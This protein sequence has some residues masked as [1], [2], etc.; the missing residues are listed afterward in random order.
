MITDN[1]IKQVVL[2]LINLNSPVD[3]ELIDE[4]LEKQ[5]QGG[6]E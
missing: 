6:D 5:I 4:D 1:D 3:Y 2:Q